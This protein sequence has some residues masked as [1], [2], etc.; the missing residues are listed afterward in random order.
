MFFIAMVW[1]STQDVLF[2][3][4]QGVPFLKPRASS[5]I[6]CHFPK[7]LSTIRVIVFQNSWN[8]NSPC[9]F[10]IWSWRFC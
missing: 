10:I 3:V 4:N 8:C 6:I 9:A 7:T 5:R 2:S 1:G